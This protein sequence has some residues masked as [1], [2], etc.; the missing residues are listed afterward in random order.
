MSATAP[1]IKLMSSGARRVV[2]TAG[3]SAS[4]LSLV[5]GLLPSSLAILGRN[6]DAT[7]T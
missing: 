4:G 2:G 1:A 7:E 5:L 6:S 3:R